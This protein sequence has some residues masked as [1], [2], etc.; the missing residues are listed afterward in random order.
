M[1]DKHLGLEFRAVIQVVT[2]AKFRKPRAPKNC[3]IHAY[4]VWGWWTRP[5]D[6]N[7]QPIDGMNCQCGCLTWTF[8]ANLPVEA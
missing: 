5:D 1:K 2:I 8:R 3:N 4:H 6:P 7:Q